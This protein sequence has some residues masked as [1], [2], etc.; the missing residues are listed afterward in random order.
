[1]ASSGDGCCF[2][3]TASTIPLV[4]PPWNGPLIWPT[5]MLKATLAG[6]LMAPTSGT[7]AVALTKSLVFT[8]A[9]SFLR[10]LLQVMLGVR[11]VRQFLRLLRQQLLRPLRLELIFQLAP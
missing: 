1:M 8:V 7:C 2:S 4:A 11:A 5:S 3:I 9:P 6:P 10:R